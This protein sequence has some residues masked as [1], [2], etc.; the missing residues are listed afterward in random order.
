MPPVL[1]TLKIFAVPR[2][3]CVF[4]DLLSY[5]ILFLLPSDFSDETLFILEDASVIS[6]IAPERARKSHFPPFDKV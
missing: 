5:H 1:Q 6:S 2:T 4:S 3:L